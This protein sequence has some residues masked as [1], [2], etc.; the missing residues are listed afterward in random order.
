MLSPE[1]TARLSLLLGS[2]P[3][4]AAARLAR[5]VEID[6]L[7]GGRGLPHDFILSTLRPMLRQVE[8]APTPLRLFCRPFEDLVSAE[9]PKEKQ[10]GRIARTSIAPVWRWLNENLLPDAASAYAAEA[11]ALVLAG[12]FEDARARAVAFWALAGNAMQSAFARDRRAVRLALVGEPIVA[13]AEEIALLLMAGSEI[14]QIQALLPRPTLELTDEM[15]RALRD[16]HDRLVV[17]LPDAAPYVAVVAMNRL[18]HPWQALKLPQ[19]VAHQSQDTLISATD[20]GLVG[21]LLFADIERHGS[22][23]RAARHPS[24]DPEAMVE[25]L[26]HFTELSSSI[27]REIDI[28]RDGKWGK[29]LLKDRAA[30]AETMDG[31]MERAPKEIVAMLPVQKSGAFGG[32]PKCADFAK[33]VDDDRAERGL[34]YARLVMGCAPYAALG[35][36]AAA[37]KDAFEEASQHLRGYNEDVVRELRAAIDAPRRAIVERQFELAAQLTALLFTL[38]EAEFLRR[39]GKAAM[40]AMAAA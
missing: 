26:S 25:H 7:S 39:R 19:L 17:A 29:R 27:V 30:V 4:Q 13:D 10:K 15:L 20:M 24:F 37:Q 22:A 2:L 18:M 12:R 36:F 5:A 38:E 40:N 8:R 23:I 28:R 34:R 33:P 3:A 6:R 9:A 14:V 21:D 35:S 16:I 32:G 31:L 11:K 1:K